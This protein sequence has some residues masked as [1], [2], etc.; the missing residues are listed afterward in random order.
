M[1]S[2]PS[3]STS[4]PN[5]NSDPN[6]P[7]NSNLSLHL[8]DTALTPL[9][10]PT[11]A[12]PP[13]T[14][15]LTTLTTTALSAYNSSR[16][17]RLGTPQRIIIETNSSGPILLHSFIAPPSTPAQSN[18]IQDR[19]QTTHTRTHIHTHGHHIQIDINGIQNINGGSSVRG[20]EILAAAREEMRPLSGTTEGSPVEEEPHDVRDEGEQ[21][22]LLIGTVVARSAEQLG[23]ARRAAHTIEI[24]ANGLQRELTKDTEGKRDR[25]DDGMAED[26]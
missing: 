4:H 13:Q 26:G 23:E 9:L 3:S 11:H 25:E 22:P 1:T 16:H 10:T 15:P 8:T 7:P 19:S 18:P 14:Q 12:N 24:L 2:R 21:A 6:P 5:P 17:L 20:L